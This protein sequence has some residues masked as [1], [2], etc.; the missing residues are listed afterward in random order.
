MIAAKTDR[1]TRK[2][3]E[4]KKD[5]QIIIMIIITTTTP[6][7]SQVALLASVAHGAEGVRFTS[8]FHPH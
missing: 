8:I 6:H 5:R 2:Q 4:R 7:A 1:K 3:T